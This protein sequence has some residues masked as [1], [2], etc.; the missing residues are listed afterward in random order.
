MHAQFFTVTGSVLVTLLPRTLAAGLGDSNTPA[1]NA[2]ARLQRRTFGD[3]AK[4][5]K[6]NIKRE[7][8]YHKRMDME[9]QAV[10]EDAEAETET[11]V[12]VVLQ[13]PNTVQ[14]DNTP[15]NV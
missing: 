2:A 10:E 12:K 6:Y 14:G 8:I 1:H 4:M 5:M 13:A 3:N 11:E 9:I 15:D 7:G